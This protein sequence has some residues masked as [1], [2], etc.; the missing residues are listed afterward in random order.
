MVG[1]EFQAGCTIFLLHDAPDAGTGRDAGVVRGIDPSDQ[2]TYNV[3]ETRVGLLVSHAIEV[4]FPSGS[5]RATVTTSDC[6]HWMR[7]APEG[8]PVLDLAAI[9]S[10]HPP[11]D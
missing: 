5:W 2:G 1:I 6:P 9:P 7:L 10:S 11:L 4:N 8:G 3:I